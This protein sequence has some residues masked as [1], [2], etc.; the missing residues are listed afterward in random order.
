MSDSRILHAM[1]AMA[2]QRAKGE[3]ASIMETYYADQDDDKYERFKES[4]EAFVKHVQDEG[5]AE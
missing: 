5:L 3:M 2:W 4:F 1:R